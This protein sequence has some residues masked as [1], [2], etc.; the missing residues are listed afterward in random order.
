MKSVPVKQATLQW[1]NKEVLTCI[2]SSGRKGDQLNQKGF[3]LLWVESLIMIHNAFPSLVLHNCNHIMHNYFVPL[4][5]AH[6]FTCRVE[7][8]RVSLVKINSAFSLHRNWNEDIKTSYFF[9]Y[10]QL[11]IG[12]LQVKSSLT[13]LFETEFWRNKTKKHF[14]VVNYAWKQSH[15]KSNTPDGHENTLKMLDF[16]FLRANTA[17]HQFAFITWVVFVHWSS[18]CVAAE[19]HKSCCF[20]EQPYNETMQTSCLT[21]LQSFSSAMNH[22]KPMHRNGP[23]SC[24]SDTRH[25]ASRMQ[26]SELLIDFMQSSQLF[27][28]SSSICT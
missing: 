6:P 15:L 9:I 8:Y 12:P 28:H 17:V 18:A 3:A 4:S 1:T 21:F 19:K 11:M 20:S 26:S 5:R 23:L 2:W 13:V 27:S 7:H 25:S 14:C 24:S 10:L 22:A 16:M